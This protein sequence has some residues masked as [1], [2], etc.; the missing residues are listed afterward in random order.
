ML[1]K[2]D[3]SR[4]QWQAWV[5]PLALRRLARDTSTVTAPL[6]ERLFGAVVLFDVSGFTALAE[7]LAT[8]GPIGAERLKERLDACFGAVTTLVH[9]HGGAVLTYPGDGV[10]ALWA[11]ATADGIADQTARAATCCLDTVASFNASTDAALQLRAGLAAGSVEVLCVGGVADRWEWLVSGD[12]VR[13][14]GAAVIAATGGQVI[15]DAAARSLLAKRAECAP[16]AGDRHRIASVSD[17]PPATGSDIDGPFD[18]DALR[19]FISA[20]VLAHLDAG[21]AEWL[22]AFRPA[23]VM[24]IRLGDAAGQSWQLDTLHGVMCAVQSVITHYGGNVNQAL[25]DDKGTIV[26][27]GW[28][29]AMHVHED[30]AARAV[31]AALNVQTALQ[32]LDCPAAI[33][34]AS[35]RI[36]TGIRGSRVRRE[37]AM[38]GDVV[39]L[40][41]RLMQGADGITCDDRTRAA[42]RQRF[43][44]AKR[45]PAAVKG[46]T[47][48][49]ATYRPVRARDDDRGDLIGRDR[50]LTMLVERTRLLA[51]AVALGAEARPQV[52]T[53]GTALPGIVVLEGEPG[54]GK[55]RL[56]AALQQRVQGT[57]LQTIVARGHPVERSSSYHAWRPVFSR[58]LH[59]DGMPAADARARVSALLESAPELAAQAPLLNA[60]FPLG[61]ADTDATRR[62]SA[63]GGAEMVRNLLVRLFS[64]ANRGLPTLLIVEDAHWLDSS[65]WAVADA[66][67]RS[68]EPLLIV[69]TTRPLL[70]SET[71]AECRRFYDRAGVVR[72]ALD[73]LTV[74]ETAALAAR[75]LAADE[76]PTEVCEFIWRRASGHPFFTE[77]LALALRDAGVIRITEG[78]CSFADRAALETL[79]L[80]D[81]VHGVVT[82]RIDRL[83]PQQQ[84]ALKIASVLGPAFTRDA[85][86]NLVP[87]DIPPDALAAD[88]EAMVTLRLL[89]ADTTADD[90]VR[91]GYMF[92]HAI[93]RQVTYDSLPFAQRR[94]L[95]GAVAR[96]LEAAA[97]RDCALLAHH[98]SEAGVAGR[99]FDYFV[100][101]GEIA[102]RADA[103]PEA[104][105]FFERALSL[106]LTD[107][108]PDPFQ[109]EGHENGHDRSKDE[110]A[111][112]RAHC[113]R[114]FGE[115]SFALGALDQAKASVDAS[116]A[117]LD[118]GR[119]RSPGRITSILAQTAVQLT[120][121]ALPRAVASSDAFRRRW[122]DERSKTAGLLALLKATPLD[123]VGMLGA[124][125]L[126]LNAAE[127]AGTTNVFGLGM[128]GYAAQALGLRRQAEKYFARARA[129]AFELNELSVY[130]GLAA[131]F[132]AMARF[133]AGDHARIMDVRRTDMQTAR[134]IGD[135]R[136]VAR[137]AMLLTSVGSFTLTVH[138]DD[139]LRWIS[140]AADAHQNQAGV[141]EAYFRCLEIASWS[142]FFRPE[143]ARLHVPAVIQ[144]I[145]RSIHQAPSDAAA[146]LAAGQ[147]LYYTRQ[148]DLA[149][150]ATAA[151]SALG[152][153]RQ[154]L[155]MVQ[156]TGWLAFHGTAEPALAIYREALATDRGIAEAGRRAKESLDLLRRYVR[157]HAIY[158]PRWEYFAGMLAWLEKRRDAADGHWQAA[159]ATAQ[160]LSLELDEGLA[161]LALADAGSRMRAAHLA[162]AREIFT[163]R[164]APY[165]VAR[166]DAI[167]DRGSAAEA[168]H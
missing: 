17:A 33:G 42:A 159:L 138:T 16:V 164:G 123:T 135:R 38:I 22:A 56:T 152:W 57:G 23:T 147:A 145:N 146:L 40:A 73:H 96:H 88:L 43:I 81:T 161:R 36:F 70:P 75:S 163:T 83:T 37:Y 140:E 84:T 110:I 7:D 63:Q 137:T 112:R 66:L 41:A 10:L 131:G 124:T 39:N 28:G 2:A 107:S 79:T 61:F 54:I 98:W 133:G 59:L 162:R 141:D 21:Q 104:A 128:L 103:N 113:H 76:L 32:Q 48:P 101:A 139:L 1:R 117:L 106:D 49:V 12:P 111:L 118:G 119:H 13:S 122:H 78:E 167:A 148:G 143:Q 109:T 14:A 74:D 62:M 89:V 126:S 55:S 65:S 86:R 60:V 144:E 155:S 121:L 142:T 136:G 94:E 34:I 51:P 53:A 85:V 134:D 35:G 92:K 26:V 80:P 58:L 52:E 46:R 153:V 45:P 150:A 90:R 24:F 50:E 115:V 151:D 47:A 130:F 120:H 64:V 18:A 77:Q 157:G 4:D 166:V 29:L 6:G 132:E 8:A 44:F 108:A 154:N 27:A 71:T 11:A 31:E 105:H 72:V 5:N 97:D 30:D 82:S 93:T 9:Q 114:R 149:G 95:H 20:P 100:Q 125:L 15:V 158:R 116:F 99:A 67:A 127:R 68:N 3:A 19:P 87:G 69:I 102:A 165:Y 25:I 129:K 156:P 160:G 168:G 91:G